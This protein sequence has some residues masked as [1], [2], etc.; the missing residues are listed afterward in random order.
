MCCSYKSKLSFKVSNIISNLLQ[1]TISNDRSENLCN[2]TFQ[3]A[4]GLEDTT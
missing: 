1:V 2:E 3:V 4:E